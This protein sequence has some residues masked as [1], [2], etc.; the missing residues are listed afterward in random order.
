MHER[1]TGHRPI[2]QADT[3]LSRGSSNP[4]CERLAQKVLPGYQLETDPRVTHENDVRRGDTFPQRYQLCLHPCQEPGL[5][6]PAERQTKQRLQGEAM[7]NGVCVYIWG[8][9]ALH[10]SLPLDISFPWLLPIPAPHTHTQLFSQVL[11]LPSQCL[12]PC[13]LYCIAFYSLSRVRLSFPRDCSLPGSSVHGIS[14]AR[15]LE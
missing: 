11:S 14:Q 2:L 13:L 1:N 9:E 6:S 3:S 5:A 8:P 15:K 10:V 4:V 7:E 12:G